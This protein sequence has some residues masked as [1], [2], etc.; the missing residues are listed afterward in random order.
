[1]RSGND[2]SSP[3]FAGL[4]EAPSSGDGRFGDLVGPIA[5]TM[6]HRL[7]Q[8]AWLGHI[9]FAF[10]L[11]HAHRPRVLVE[12]GTHNGASYAAFCQAIAELELEVL[13]PPKDRTRSPGLI[14]R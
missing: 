11:I 3:R 9:P 6:P 13:L 12:L 7:V 2:E 8:S 5:F 14:G 4:P 10:W 1:M